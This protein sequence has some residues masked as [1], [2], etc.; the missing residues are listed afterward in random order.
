MRL[1]G[2]D[3]SL[4]VVPVRT[5]CENESVPYS[6]QRA[7]DG[8]QDISENAKA[9]IS[10]GTALQELVGWLLRSKDQ[11]AAQVEGAAETFQEQGR[12]TENLK[13]NMN[14]VLRAKQLSMEYRQKA[15]QLFI[16]AADIAGP[17]L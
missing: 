15:G 1:N 14:E 2:Y 7:I 5:V 4:C 17:H 13:E 11:M 16:E 12:L 8:V 9:T 10:K 6:L 3:F